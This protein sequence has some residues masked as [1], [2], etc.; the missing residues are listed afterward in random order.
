MI[1]QAVAVAG[2][3]RREGKATLMLAACAEKIAAF[4]QAS[5]AMGGEAVAVYEN[6]RTLELKFKEVR[7]S[8]NA[9]D[10]RV[11]EMEEKFHAKIRPAVDNKLFNIIRDAAT[12]ACASAF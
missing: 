4:E 2:R 11:R 6:F 9:L 7:N 10:T 1:E 5:D 12:R 3:R 8:D